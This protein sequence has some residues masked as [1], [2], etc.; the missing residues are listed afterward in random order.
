MIF[1]EW[2]EWFQNGDDFIGKLL[3]VRFQKRTE[4][5]VPFLAEEGVL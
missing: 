3:T 2:I 1:E 4:D 5:N